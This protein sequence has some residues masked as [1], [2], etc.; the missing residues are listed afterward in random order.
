[1]STVKQLLDFKGHEVI[2]IDPDATVYAAVER[3]A[4]RQIGALLVLEQGRL[5]GLFSERDYARKVVLKGKSSRET[6]VRDVM[7]RE[8]IC[9]APDTSVDACMALMT[10]K[11]VRHLPVLEQGRLIGIVT[12]GD[13]VR[14]LM[15][16]KDFTIT[17]LEQYIFQG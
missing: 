9:V 15:A 8:L 3:M 5:A 2:A 17:Q 1:M 14:Q 13:A 16:D 6:L 7:T 4:E 11:R 12:I 10:A